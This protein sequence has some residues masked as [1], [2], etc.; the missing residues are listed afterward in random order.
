M[1]VGNTIPTSIP[2]VGTTVDTLTRSSGN[3]F[4]ADKTTGSKTGQV[5][6][7]LRGA[8][9]GAAK[10]RFGATY[11]YGLTTSDDPG[12]LTNGAIS[13]SINIEAALGTTLT[14]TEHA[15]HVRYALSAMLK[16][17]LVE[18]LMSGTVL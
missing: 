17:S 11:R 10:R 2:A 4:V 1:A 8:Q 7:S 6:L 13:V 16:A 15:K 18:D 9:A 3:T 12:A 14:A 5:I